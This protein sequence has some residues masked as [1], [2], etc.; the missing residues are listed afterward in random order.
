MDINPHTQPWDGEGEFEDYL[1]LSKTHYRQAKLAYRLGGN[2]RWLP[3]YS[4]AYE[5]MANCKSAGAEIWITT[6]R[7]WQRLDN[8]DPDTRFWLERH[9]LPY[10]HMLYDEDKLQKIVDQVDSARIVAVIDDLHEQYD[11]AIA[12]DLPVM[13]RANDHNQHP[14]KSRPQKGTLARCGVWA[15]QEIFNW[16][17]S[18]QI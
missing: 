17:R 12:L 1:G 16:K 6:T 13:Q 10:D 5:A 4:E 15:R 8:I 2:K 14:S 3:I 11:R 7:P 18:H 9:G